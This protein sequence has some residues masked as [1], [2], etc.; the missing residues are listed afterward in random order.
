MKKKMKLLS[1]LFASVLLVASLSAC[2]TAKT[3]ETT[4]AEVT[5]AAETT[6]EAVVYTQQKTATVT[7]GFGNVDL[8]CKANADIS[9]IDITF[10]AFDDTQEVSGK[11]VAG[12]FT[13][14]Y[15][16]TGFFGGDAQAMYD[17]IMAGT[18]AWAP[19]Q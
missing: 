4:K 9:K 5:T 7:L 10:N 15:D 16:K 8:T 6:T 14:S 17:G 12:K 3:E 13:P 18:T 1:V 2:G 19:I 11:V